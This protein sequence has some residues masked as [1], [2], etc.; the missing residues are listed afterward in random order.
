LDWAQINET[1]NINFNKIIFFYKL[2]CSLTNQLKGLLV[3]YFSYIIPN[4]ILLLS[5]I[6]TASLS[7]SDEPKLPIELEDDFEFTRTEVALK[8]VFK[9]LELC[10]LYDRIHF[11][12]KDRF[13]SLLDPLIKQL[14]LLN[15]NSNGKDIYSNRMERH[16]IPCIENLAVNIGNES[17]WKPLNYK[18]LIK[19]GSDNPTV[20]YYALLTILQLY[21]KIGEEFLPLLPESMQYISELL[22]DSDPTVESLA[23]DFIK[24]I[25]ILMG[26]ENEIRELFK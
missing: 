3:P 26:D 2:V 24:K 8:W 15:D 11:I 17:L 4:V 19:T 18:L 20:R 25:G 13:E 6:F 23:N 16:F 12:D 22:E 21:E 14:E 10:F 9:S 5:S 7:G 1:E